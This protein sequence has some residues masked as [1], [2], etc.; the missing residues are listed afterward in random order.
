MLYQLAAFALIA[1]YS[2][3]NLARQ[4]I[5]FNAKQR[6]TFWS[7][8][9]S[10]KGGGRCSPI[11]SWETWYGA[12]LQAFKQYFLS[13]SFISHFFGFFPNSTRPRCCK[14]MAFDRNNAGLWSAEGGWCWSD[15][16]GNCFAASP[17]VFLCFSSLAASHILYYTQLC[18]ARGLHN[19]QYI[20][21][22]NATMALTQKN[23][24]W[25]QIS[26]STLLYFK[27]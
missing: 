6:S 4:R 19:T 5:W 15:K 11:S 22:Y 24:L 13:L 25:I 1:S 17:L 26:I 8:I 3:P 2:S 9:R 10:F 20:L 18:R 27:R 14:I 21:K 16:T 12:K 23:L 7:E